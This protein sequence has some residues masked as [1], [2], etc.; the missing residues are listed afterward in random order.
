MVKLMALLTVAVVVGSAMGRKEGGGVDKT[1]SEGKGSGKAFGLDKKGVS[2]LSNR[3]IY[4]KMV[5]TCRSKTPGDS[6]PIAADNITNVDN[7]KKCGLAAGKIKDGVPVAF[8]DNVVSEIPAEPVCGAGDNNATKVK[9]LK[10]LRAHRA[11]RTALVYCAKDLRTVCGFGAETDPTCTEQVLE[12]CPNILSTTDG[13]PSLDPAALCACEKEN[14]QNLNG[15]FKSNEG[16][17]NGRLLFNLGGGG[18]PDS[19]ANAKGQLGGAIRSIKQCFGNN[20]DLLSASCTTAINALAAKAAAEKAELD[21]AAG[22]TGRRQLATVDLSPLAEAA[23]T[24]DPALQLNSARG[25]AAPLALALAVL[26]LNR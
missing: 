4:G 25:L 16:L 9:K 22:T 8:D 14:S 6:T 15:C 23:D 2:M 11:L 5:S 1:D 13:V 26:A 10:E 19:D 18:K 3:L 21:A 7:G 17:G 20:T 12:A 24:L